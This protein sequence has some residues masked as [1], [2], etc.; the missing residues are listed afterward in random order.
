[1]RRHRL[2]AL[3]ASCLL[4]VAGCSQ[5]AGNGDTHPS[6]TTQ[7][8]TASKAADPAW[9]T[10]SQLGVTYQVPASWQ[11]GFAPGS[12]WCASN[13]VPSAPG[14]ITPAGGEIGLD[15][16][17]PAMPSE[18]QVPHVRLSVQDP[19][20][21]KRLSDEGWATTPPGEREHIDAKPALG[22]DEGQQPVEEEY[23]R[24]IQ[25][26]G[27]IV[28]TVAMPVEADDGE[29]ASQILDTATAAHTSALGCPMVVADDEGSDIR[30]S[31]D[32]DLTVCHYASL[33]ALSETETELSAE[34]QYPALLIGER[35]L[36][37]EQA[38]AWRQ[39]LTQAPTD[40][41]VRIPPAQG[42]SWEPMFVQVRA[43]SGGVATVRYDGAGDLGTTTAGHYFALTKPT[44]QPLFGDI[45]P[46]LAG[47]EQTFELCSTEPD[48]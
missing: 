22:A 45:V 5:A 19:E 35:Q 47:S 48:Q 11:A 13:E 43:A 38:T 30:D 42:A 46:M 16:G 39:A 17:C 33:A 9:Q 23:S 8:A 40:Q 24:Y 44:C 21:S 14:L 37:G 27:P 28:V 12:D 4:V 31:T 36:A 10:I 2:I 20:L 32:A 34:R 7:P 25:H 15:I 26:I 41:P 29:L 6:P 1:M 3:S 18:Y